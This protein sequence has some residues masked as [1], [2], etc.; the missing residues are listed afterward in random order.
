MWHV[1]REAGRLPQVSPR[2]LAWHEQQ[3]SQPNVSACA[4]LRHSRSVLSLDAAWAAAAEGTGEGE[5]NVLLALH[6]HQE[7][8]HV[9][10]LLADTADTRHTRRRTRAS[11]SASCDSFPLLC[12]ARGQLLAA[13]TQTDARSSARSLPTCHIV[14][15]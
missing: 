7:G 5:V 12:W 14:C 9:H 10:D 15:L 4:C 1:H 2:K 8:G 13:R 6:A 11:F 3:A